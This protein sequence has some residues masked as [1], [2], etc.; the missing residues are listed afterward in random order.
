MLPRLWAPSGWKRGSKLMN[1]MRIYRIKYSAFYFIELDTAGSRAH[2]VQ[3]LKASLRQSHRERG[4]ELMSFM[5]CR[6]HYLPI[7]FITCHCRSPSSPPAQESAMKGKPV[8][9]PPTQG[10]SESVPEKFAAAPWR[11]QAKD[12]VKV[13]AASEPSLQSETTT[14]PTEKHPSESAQQDVLVL[15]VSGG[16]FTEILASSAAS[17]ADDA[18][19]SSTIPKAFRAG[20]TIPG[21]PS[22]PYCTI[23]F[24]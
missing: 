24:E 15:E 21:V 4:W 1:F 5:H 8:P 9:E 23:F 10:Q 3:R 7:V 11:Q 13:E 17:T 14:R 6:I 20:K 19:S 12:P 2:R 18:A 16:N 22:G